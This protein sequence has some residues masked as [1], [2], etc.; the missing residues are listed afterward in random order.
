MKPK[1]KNAV[2]A[3]DKIRA[4]IACRL[5]VL[6]QNSDIAGEPEIPRCDDL[7]IRLGDYF[8]TFHLTTY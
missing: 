2:V 3:T 4:W 1:P 6:D 8:A 7:R 5:S